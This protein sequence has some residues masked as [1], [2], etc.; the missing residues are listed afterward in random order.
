MKTNVF[1][2]SLLLTQSPSAYFATTH[3]NFTDHLVQDFSTSSLFA[4]LEFLR[5]IVHQRK[6]SRTG[7]GHTLRRRNHQFYSFTVISNILF[8]SLMADLQL[9]I[10]IGLWPYVNFLSEIGKLDTANNDGQVGIIAIEIMPISFRITSEAL[11]R[12]KMCQEIQ[13]IL[14]FHEWDK[15]MLIPHS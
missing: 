15:F 2:L 12:E 14:N 9:G 11:P 8:S 10:G 7:T 5:D 13:R 6:P 4:Q 3:S 1:R